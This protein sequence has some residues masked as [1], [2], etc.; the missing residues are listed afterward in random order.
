[1][2]SAVN[3][4]LT[5]KQGLVHSKAELEEFISKYL[6]GS[7]PD[8]QVSAW[9]MAVCLKGMNFEETIRLT[10]VMINSGDVLDLSTLPYTVDKHST[11]G[12]GDK[13]TLVVAPLVAACGAT[14]AKMSGRGL[15]H[16]GG[17][18]D[19]LESIPNFRTTLKYEDFI[20][21]ARR[22]GLV[23]TAQS[24]NLVPADGKLY[25]LRDVTATIDSLP[26]IA[27]SIMSKKLASGAKNIALDIK[28]GK[29][30]L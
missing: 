19:K 27:S 17:T 5:K 13:T 2:V 29:G 15:G 28:V 30:R 8:Y 18:I 20:E 7:I 24:K 3:F 22:V 12:V 10:E 26:L 11:G 1:M 16:T 6:T 4:I 9:L 14:L 25:A 21:Q 23:I